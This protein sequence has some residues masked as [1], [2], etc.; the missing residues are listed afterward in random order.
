MLGEAQ[1]AQ[2]FSRRLF[3]A[4][5]FA[6]ATVYP[7]VPMGKA[8]VRVMNSASHSQEDLGQALSIFGQ[9]GR[10]LEVID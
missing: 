1:V 8:R 2:Q 3:E 10:S 7:T 9:V 4:G 6:T 5:L